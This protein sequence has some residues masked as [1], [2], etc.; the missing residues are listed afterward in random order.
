MTGISAAAVAR[1]R[2]LGEPRWSPGGDPPGLA[3]RLRRSGRP[4]GGAGRRQRARRDPHRRDPGH[5]ARRLRRGW[6]LLG[7]RRHAG[8]RRR[9]R[10][11]ARGRRRPGEPVA[12][13]V[14]RR[15]RRR[16][17]GRHPTATGW[18][19]CSSATT[20]ATSRV[21]DVDGLA[22]GRAG[23]RT[24]TT[25]GTRR[26][27]PTAARLAWHEWDLPNM[28]WDGSRIMTVVVDEPDAVATPGRGRRRRRRRPAAVRARRATRSR[29]SPSST[30]G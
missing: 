2:T 13:A 11:P 5:R 15:A 22:A 6:L 14:P 28:P 16:A 1:S 23:S 7:R 19:S 26:G 20:P 27:R 10:P 4:R 29:S 25:P 3:R 18:P 9:R 24:P 30:A 17:G 21:V 12:G 8:L